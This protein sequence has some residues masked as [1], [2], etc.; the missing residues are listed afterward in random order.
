MC[1]DQRTRLRCKTF[2]SYLLLSYL[3]FFSLPYSF[4]TYFSLTY[5]TLLLSSLSFFSYISSL[6]Y[7]ILLLLFSLLFFF[8]YSSFLFENRSKKRKGKREG[9]ILLLYS[10]EGRLMDSG[11]PNSPEIVFEIPKLSFGEN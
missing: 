10:R 1:T 9:P 7:P 8:S 2:S 4:L 3:S 6:T 11:N 5:P